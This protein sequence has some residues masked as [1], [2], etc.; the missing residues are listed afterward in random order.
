M[1]NTSTGYAL[2]T[3]G[4]IWKTTDG[5]VT[6][7]DT[8]D[9][10]ISGPTGRLDYRTKMLAISATVCIFSNQE[11][12]EHYNNSTNTVKSV[13]VNAATS[14]TMGLIQTTDGTIYTMFSHESVARGIYLYKSTDSGLHWQQVLIDPI[15]YSTAT[16]KFKNCLSEIG[17]TNHI[18]LVYP[19]F[20]G[21]A[22]ANMMKIHKG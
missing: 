2:D 10:V 8:T 16:T 12:I 13:I 7:T 20:N 1:F 18:I 9:D 19:S 4:N 17:S 6:W 14:R 15:T 3:D 5:A 11:S 21:T 22:R